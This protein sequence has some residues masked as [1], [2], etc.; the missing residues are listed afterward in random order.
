[1]TKINIKQG[2]ALLFFLLLSNLT[3]AQYQKS[4]NL[5]NGWEF[6]IS[7]SENWRPAEVPGSVQMDLFRLGDLE[8]PFYRTNELKYQWVDKENWV[9]KTS[10]VLDSSDFAWHSLLLQFEG[11]D[12]YAKVQLN[13]V[14]ILQ[15][16]NMFLE[17][18]VEV[19]SL[20]KVGQNHLEIRFDS[21]IERALPFYKQSAYE[22]PAGNDQAKE[23]LSVYTRK[24]PYHYGWD[25]GP[26]FVTM[27]IWRPIRL[28]YQHNF[29]VEEM[30][31]HTKSLT[32]QEAE[33][34]VELKISSELVRHAEVGVFFN[35]EPVFVEKGKMQKGINDLKVNWTVA[36]PELW[37]PNGWGDQKL[38]DLRVEL[39]DD[40]GR[41]LDQKKIKL[42]IRTIEVI[43]D[44]DSI[45]ESFFVKVNGQPIF[46]KG[47]NYIPQDNFLSRVGAQRYRQLLND[48]VG[49][50]MNMLRVWGGGIYEDDLFYELCDELGILVWQDFMFACSMYPGD[51]NFVESVN[52]E[53]AYNIKRLRNHTSLALWCG[54]NEM[55]VAWHN[56]GWQK[57]LG[58]SKQD[59]TEIWNNYVHMFDVVLPEAVKKHDPTRFYFPSSPISNWGKLEDMNYGDNHYWGV[60]HGEHPFE[61][62]NLYVARFN[63]EYG[64]QSFP[65]LSTVKKYTEAADR[66]IESKV[67]L[68]HQRHPRG[69]QLI[70][71]YLQ[72]NYGEAKDFESF[73]Y[74]SQLQQAEGL[75]IAFEGHRRNMPKSMGTLYWQLNDCWPVASWSSIDYYGNW[76][77]LHYKAKKAFAPTKLNFYEENG[78][79]S[80]YLINDKTV[81]KTGEVRL[82]MYDIETGVSKTLAKPTVSIHTNT[83][84]TVWSQTS[85]KIAKGKKKK[86]QYLVAKLLVDGQE[87]DRAV[88]HFERFKD[89]PLPKANISVKKVLENGNAFIEVHSNAYAK[90]V[91]LYQ[92]D[93]ILQLKDNYID[94]LPG[95][96]IKIKIESGTDAPIQF[97]HL[98]EALK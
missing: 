95:E 85:K 72:K 35:E 62:Y 93:G 5:N 83:V 7:K 15:S 40:E 57:S 96:K 43:N 53:A 61:S 89:I 84:K 73:L 78:V 75:N 18:K 31:V 37:W 77:A 39:R 22:L 28:L 2:I 65:E 86:L 94:L 32:E 55:N 6:K 34:E 44:A 41:L 48:V 79:L 10:F 4:T 17:H 98:K 8:D 11:L 14:D 33:M 76:K 47:A 19:K 21:P 91:Y 69:N 49:A 51:S 9:Y 50:N 63:S 13:G 30:Y 36:Q 97:I 80:L 24:A 45:G 58:Y 90:G 23:R 25:W 3:T 67:M 56:W 1:M 66:D 70:Q 26:R 38:H 92:E 12:T 27:G 20:L 60:W 29:L 87:V 46:M 68:S 88:Y 81:A 52:K 59:S 71:S 16:D 64:F 54:N 82:E 42:G 74:L